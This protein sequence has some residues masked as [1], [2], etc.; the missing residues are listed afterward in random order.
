MDGTTHLSEVVLSGEK[1]AEF[2]TNANQA[3]QDLN[4]KVDTSTARF[5]SL[6]I[7]KINVI[8]KQN[9]ITI[10]SMDNAIKKAQTSYSGFPDIES[11]KKEKIKEILIEAFEK[12]SKTAK[13]VPATNIAE[14]TGVKS[15]NSGYLAL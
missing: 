9:P 10:S 7:E 3:V 13:S 6:V 8:A 2:I 12:T 5:N 11:D 4:N 14:Q 15:A 1:K